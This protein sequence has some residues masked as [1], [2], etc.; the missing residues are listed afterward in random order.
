MT[1]TSAAQPLTDSISRLVASGKVVLPPL[2]DLVNRLMELL[3]DRERTSSKEVANLVGTDP[4]IAATLL[5]WANSAAFGGLVPVSDLSLAIARLGFRQ[6]T[7][8]VTTVAH[9]A[10]FRSDDPVKAE[11][12]RALWVHAVATAAASKHIANL[13]GHGPE[14]AFVAGLLHDTG[15]L[16]VLKAVDQLEATNKAE[17]TPVVLDELMDVLHTRLGYDS[18]IA[19]RVPKPICEAV[20]HHHDEEPDPGRPLATLVQAADAVACKTG[21]HL[22]P[23]PDMDLMSLPSVE[24]MNLSDIELASTMVDVEDQVAEIKSLL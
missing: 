24:S 15:K 18:L 13:R 21:F 3:K 10:N 23:E 20:L 9:S 2:P 19:W 8:A 1:T 12:L 17:I 14:E 16:L 7:S 4:A 5:R 22:R 6:V 11:I